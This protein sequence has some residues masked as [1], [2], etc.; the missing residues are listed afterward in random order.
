[1]VSA[2]IFDFYGTLAH[3]ADDDGHNYQAVLAAHGYALDPT[4]LQDYFARYDGVDHAEHSVSE[5]AYEAWV[6][7]RLGDLTAA[8]GVEGSRAE[9]VIDALRD[10][11][12]GGM[13]AYPEAAATLSALRE[14]GLA[15]GV[16]SNWGWEL[17]AF[18]RE[19]APQVASGA[20]KYREDIRQGLETVPA[21]FAEML[22]GDNFGKMLVRVGV[23]PTG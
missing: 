12:R 15:V 11:D 2:V 18:L 10:S 6:R 8:C 7:A 16:C 14:A 21:C 1:V 13:V 17:D 20:L 4:V 3:W 5:E 23:D 9:L 22:R 19:V